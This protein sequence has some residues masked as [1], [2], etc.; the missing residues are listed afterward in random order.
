MDIIMLITAFGGGILGAAIGGVPAFV[1]TGL[2]VIAAVLAGDAGQ[3]VLNM[4]CFGPIFGPHVAFGGAVAATAY[5]RKCGFVKDGQNLSFPLF[6]TGS[7]RVLLVGGIFGVINFVIQF[8]YSKLLGGIVFGFEGWTDTVALTVFTSGV[9]VRLLMTKSGLTG[10]YTGTEKR[11]FVPKGKRLHFLAA[12]GV[13]VGVITSGFAVYLG[14]MA[15]DGSSAALYIFQNIG[16]LGFALAAF[17]LLFACVG[18]PIESWHHTAVTSATTAMIVFAGTLNPAMTIIAA[19]V[20]GVI[21]S[22]A[23][24]CAQ[25]TFNS[26][27]D[28]HIDPPATVIMLM[29]IINFSVIQTM[30]PS[31][32]G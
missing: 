14:R 1:F 25:L 4:L 26:Y 23:N 32:M 7:A 5:A 16:N 10:K 11:Q 17:S 28:S 21:I 18:L 30:L 6:G 20:V 9:L 29:Q 27:A 22:V 15:V 2:T 13:G 8:I 24:E 31:I 19:V 12:T 3:P